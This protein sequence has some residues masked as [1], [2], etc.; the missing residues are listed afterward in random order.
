MRLIGLAVVLAVDLVLAPLAAG[1]QQAGKVYRIGWL[2]PAPSAP[3][4]AQLEAL[5]KGLPEL[6]YVEGRNI[7]IE[8]RWADGDFAQLPRLARTLV[9]RKVD[10]ICSFGTPATLAAKQATTTIPVSSA[11]SGWA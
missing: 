1:A 6:G 11:L 8:A 4:A 9:E 7:V 5:R 2:S 10:V 3:G